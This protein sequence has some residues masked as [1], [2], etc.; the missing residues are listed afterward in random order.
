MGGFCDSTAFFCLFL[1]KRWVFWGTVQRFCSPRPPKCCT[2]PKTT[3]F[4]KNKVHGR[5]S[6]EQ[7]T[8]GSLDFLHA[9][10]H[11]DIFRSRTFYCLD[12]LSVKLNFLYCNSQNSIYRSCQRK[13]RYFLYISIR[14]PSEGLDPEPMQWTCGV[15]A[16]IFY[17]GVFLCFCRFS[18]VLLRSIYS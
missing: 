17:W 8:R 1:L 5:P 12:I 7:D 11:I 3:M 13:N 6:K 2:V 9:L 4:L 15:F 16:L 18:W 14:T 10:L